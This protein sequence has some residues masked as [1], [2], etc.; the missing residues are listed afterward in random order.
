[1]LPSVSIPPSYS[2]CC[3]EINTMCYILNLKNQFRKFHSHANNFQ[4][5]NK[6]NRQ[7]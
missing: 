1:M 7:K 3:V 2:V 5:D 4:E 6:C